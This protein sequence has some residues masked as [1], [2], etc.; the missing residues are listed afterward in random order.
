M[1]YERSKRNPSIKRNFNLKICAIDFRVC[2]LIKSKTFRDKHR[3]KRSNN[4][5]DRSGR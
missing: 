4:A 5:F 2:H 1:Q 3:R